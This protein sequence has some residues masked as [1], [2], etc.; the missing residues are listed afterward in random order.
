M[1]VLTRR[2]GEQVMIGDQIAVTVLKVTDRDKVYLGI[3]A[4]NELLILR[5]EL[6]ERAARTRV[7]SLPV[8]K[9]PS[10]DQ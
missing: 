6:M 1:L 4:P 9:E 3:T 5:A 10:C 2:P 8:D 7:V